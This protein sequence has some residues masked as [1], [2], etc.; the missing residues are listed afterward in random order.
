MKKKLTLKDW[1][2][3]DRPREKMVKYGALALNN[4]ELLAIILR[5]GVGDENAVELARRVLFGCGNNLHRLA[6]MSPHDI[7]MHYKG[8]GIA[9][10]TAIVAAMELGRRREGFIVEAKS[11]IKS[12]ADA[13]KN[14]AVELCDLDHEE[15]W[16][17]M[18]S[19][20]NT[21]IEKIRLASGGIDATVVDIRMLL[22][23][24]LER[25]T[26][27]VVVAHNHPSGSLSPSNQDRDLTYR[28]KQALQVMDIKLLDHIIVGGGSYFSFSD[29]NLL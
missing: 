1:E 14:L 8:I 7:I 5:S 18:L 17:V 15:F 11:V 16:V 13:F 23:R 21:V 27:G 12:S 3:D 24:V 26:V 29:N 10:A 6:R 20:A 28:I 2:S 9:K 19:R 25:N 4:V 22:R